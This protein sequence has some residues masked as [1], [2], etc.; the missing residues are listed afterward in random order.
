MAAHIKQTVYEDCY[1]DNVHTG[2]NTKNR[3][4]YTD[5]AGRYVRYFTGAKKYIDAQNHYRSDIYSVPMTRG[6][7][8]VRELQSKLGV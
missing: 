1:L 4:V 2:T 7:D 6:D 5:K 8:I 3:V